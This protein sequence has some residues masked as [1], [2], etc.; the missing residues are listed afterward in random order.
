MQ[1]NKTHDTLVVSL[2]R[3]H[4]TETALPKGLVMKSPGVYEM[5]VTSNDD[6]FSVL[7]SIAKSRI[8]VDNI[9]LKRENLEDV[10]MRVVGVEP[11]ES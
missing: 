10:F 1:K 4:A 7:D 8:P 5:P 6:L 11:D 2:A 3:D 9:Y